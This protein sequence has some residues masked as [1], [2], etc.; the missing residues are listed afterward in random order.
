MPGRMSKR[1]G[2]SGERECAAVLNDMF[3]TSY[4]RGRQYHGGTDSPDI[5]GGPSGLHVEVKRTE[6]LS[7]YPALLQAATDAK[8]DIPVVMHRANGKP[9]VVC[10]ELKHLKALAKWVVA[11]DSEDVT[12]DLIATEAYL[13]EGPED[14]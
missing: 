3:G 13:F 4:H 7:L 9:W 8:N 5:A 6:R 2:A 10:L 14:D 12:D 11:L 1:K